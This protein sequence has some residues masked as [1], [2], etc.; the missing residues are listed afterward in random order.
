MLDAGIIEQVEESKWIIPMVVQD[1]NT[2][3]VHIYVDLWKLNKSCLHDPFST[4]FIDEVL[5]GLG[6]QK[7]YSFTDGFS[8]YH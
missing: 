1:K 5:G 4:S 3:E 8:G 2:S 7:I 6:G